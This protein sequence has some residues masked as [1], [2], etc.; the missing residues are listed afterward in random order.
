MVQQ[1]EKVCKWN[2]KIKQQF[3]TFFKG[4][5]KIEIFIKV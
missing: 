4:I 3:E 2:L 5:K 1:F